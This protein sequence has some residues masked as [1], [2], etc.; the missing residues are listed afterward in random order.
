[1]STCTGRSLVFTFLHFTSFP[2][3]NG[4]FGALQSC[5]SAITLLFAVCGHQTMVDHY[6][7]SGW[8]GSSSLKFLQNN[9][10]FETVDAVD[11]SITCCYIPMRTVNFAATKAMTRRLC[12][13]S[14]GDIVGPRLCYFL[15]SRLCQLY[16][17][18]K[19]RH[20]RRPKSQL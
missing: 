5:K 4:I 1:M 6:H 13:A 15:K 12:C 8:Q 14:V 11:A 20:R 2:P 18:M 3:N 19:L 17:P 10:F 7:R 9:H 16:S